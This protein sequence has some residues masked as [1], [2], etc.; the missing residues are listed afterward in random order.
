MRRA[1]PV[2][3]L[4]AL[5]LTAGCSFLG[6]GG[7]P[8]GADT[9]TPTASPTTTDS[10]TPTATPTPDTSQSFPAGYGESGV[11][12]A[13]TALS[14]HVDG[15]AGHQSFIVEINGSVAAS[16]GTRAL[17][18]LQ[19]VD[20]A[21]DRALIA[22]NGTSGVERT[23]YFG[24]G[25]RYVRLDPPGENNTRYNVTN[26]TLEPRGFTGSGF[27][28]PVLT[29]ASYG[30]ANVTETANGTF[31]SYTATSVDRSAFRALLGP[32]VDPENVTR[33]DAG[34]VVDEEGIVRRMGY[35]A[36]VDRGDEQVVVRIDLRTY[37][38]DEVDISPPPWLD[39]ARQTDSS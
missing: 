30:E 19:S 22:V 16:N 2:L 29:N 18:Q 33:F 12:D 6:G 24:D 5:V 36:V 20:I 11:T 25:K 10:P 38:I 31:Y 21:D 39:E 28:A 13:E 3:L 17:R 37:A 4:A 7:T 15:L 23:S 34:I 27:L 9:P 35:Q 1:L 26:A 14:N 8:T 32:S